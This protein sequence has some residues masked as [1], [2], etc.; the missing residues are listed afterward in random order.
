M[1]FNRT[2]SWRAC[3]VERVHLA[4][5]RSS[6]RNQSLVVPRAAEPAVYETNMLLLRPDASIIDSLLTLG[7]GFRSAM[8][9]D[10]ESYAR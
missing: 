2:N 4:T 5:A 7:I 10:V 3:L 6:W 8:R 9:L 1:L